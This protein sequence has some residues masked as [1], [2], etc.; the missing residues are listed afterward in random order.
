MKNSVFETA[1]T[2]KSLTGTHDSN[3]VMNDEVETASKDLK[4]YLHLY[5]SSVPLG[6]SKWYE[7]K[8]SLY[9]YA[10]GLYG[11]YVVNTWNDD[12]KD[13]T[14][15]VGKSYDLNEFNQLAVAKPLTDYLNKL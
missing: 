9:E 15:P 5:E 13:T 7:S 3:K 12:G 10:D 11:L 14:Q 2:V 1:L 8:L 4:P 6:K